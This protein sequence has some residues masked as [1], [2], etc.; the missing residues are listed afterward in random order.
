MDYR[1][2]LSGL[3]SGT[4]IVPGAS[5]DSHVH[6]ETNGVFGGW[7]EIRNPV[8]GN[9]LTLC[10]TCRNCIFPRNVNFANKQR[11][12]WEQDEVPEDDKTTAG[13]IVDAPSKIRLQK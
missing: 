1:S 13:L 5:I 3:D 8:N 10:L 2:S 12:L 7:I 11:T 6:P 9:W 4:E